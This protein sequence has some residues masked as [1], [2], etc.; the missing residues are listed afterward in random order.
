[1]EP[2]GARGHGTLS[3]SSRAGVGV[4]ARDSLHG[5][6]SVGKLS[7]RGACLVIVVR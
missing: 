4:S 7:R 6:L 2:P 1:M 5:R 3:V